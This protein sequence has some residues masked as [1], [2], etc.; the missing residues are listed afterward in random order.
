M[1][2]KKKIVERNSRFGARII[3]LVSYILVQTIISFMINMYIEILSYHFRA[4]LNKTCLKNRWIEIE[5]L[6]S[7][8]IIIPY[9]IRIL[10]VHFVSVFSPYS[11][12]KLY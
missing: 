5:K 12:F 8:I 4:K 7:K 3:F 1:S 2:T 6:E 9:F 11:Y 10:V